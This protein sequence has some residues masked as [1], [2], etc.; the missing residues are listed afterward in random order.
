M[1]GRAYCWGR[2]FEGNLGDGTTTNRTTPVLVS[3]GY[4]WGSIT[5]GQEH[6]CGVTT[7][8]E[9]YCWGDNGSGRLGDGTTTDRNTPTK[10]GG[11]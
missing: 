5:V 6:T 10:V 3:G 7:A 8:G 9:A 11:G 1:A 2:N 4:T